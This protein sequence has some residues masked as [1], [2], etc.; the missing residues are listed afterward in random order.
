MT[1]LN[2]GNKRM[3]ANLSEYDLIILCG[4]IWMGKFITPLKSFVKKNLSAVNEL[5]F[6][7]CCGSSYKLKDEKFG[8]G[9][10]F[11][12]IE[13]ILHKKC[14]HCE[15]FPITLVIPEDKREDTNTVMNTRLTAENF[16]GEILHNFNAF[17]DFLIAKI[18]A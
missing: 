4:P 9:L 7:T 8:H 10:V 6:A 16:K 5:I 3:Q 2:L 13:E 14:L 17:I 15:A 11:K 18:N 12:E 1:G